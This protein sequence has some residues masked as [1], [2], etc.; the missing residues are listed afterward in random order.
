MRYG[1]GAQATAPNG[2]FIIDLWAGVI[3]HMAN[4]SKH[5]FG[6]HSRLSLNDRKY[7]TPIARHLPSVTASHNEPRVHSQSH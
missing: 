6:R 5:Y 1:V 2:L 3:N 7:I 4:T